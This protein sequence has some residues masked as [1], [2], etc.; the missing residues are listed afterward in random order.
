MEQ[1]VDTVLVAFIVAL[2]AV[3]LVLIPMG[4]VWLARRGLDRLL[5]WH[6]HRTFMKWRR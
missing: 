3:T 5:A 4:L 2:V 1:A 6:R